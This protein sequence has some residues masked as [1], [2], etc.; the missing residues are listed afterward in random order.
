M[1][2][3]SRYF[4]PKATLLRTIDCMA[5]LKLNKLHLHLV[6]DNGWR[7]EIKRYPRLTQVGA[8]RVKRDEPFPARK[9]PLPGEQTTGGILHPTGD[10]R[11]YSITPKA[12]RSK[13]F[14]K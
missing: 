14:R 5:L 6:D 11:D 12:G 13:L 3:V 10:E 8:W 7:L 2:D 1:L 4:I 9:N